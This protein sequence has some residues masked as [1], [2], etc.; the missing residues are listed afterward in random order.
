MSSTIS[1]SQ[2][3]DFI[4]ILNNAFNSLAV[5]EVSGLFHS[6]EAYNLNEFFFLSILQRS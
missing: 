5:Q 1:V 6:H 2:H 4:D 3:T